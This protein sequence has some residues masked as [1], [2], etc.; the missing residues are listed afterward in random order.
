MLAFSMNFPRDFNCGVS[1]SY[2]SQGLC[3]VFDVTVVYH[4]LSTQNPS[5]CLSGLGCEE[6]SCEP[7]G[8]IEKRNQR[9]EV[10]MSIDLVRYQRLER[11]EVRVTLGLAVETLSGEA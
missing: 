5:V 6:T 8:G 3:Y 2:S 4:D 11:P 1:Y 9:L 10:N 7:K